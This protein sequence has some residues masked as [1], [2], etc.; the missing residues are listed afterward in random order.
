LARDRVYLDWNA[1]APLRPEARE[2][3]AGAWDLV[4]NPSSVHAEGRASRRLVEDA[5]AVIAGAVGADARN[6]VFTSGGT[7]ANSL[8]LTPGLRQN[9]GLAINRLVVSAIEHAS[10]LTGGRFAREAIEI[11]GVSKSGVVDLGHLREILA[12]G[13]PALVSVMAANNETGALQP[14][15]EVADIV[16]RAGGLLHTDAVQTL[17]KI[18]ID[19][20]V[21]QADLI[22]VS[23]HKIGGPK[24]VGALVLADGLNGLEAAIRGGGQEKGRRAGTEN[25]PGIVG[26]GAAVK[27]AMA[28]LSGDMGRV[29]N[30][31][32]RLETAL[33][34]T[35]GAFVFS[36]AAPRLPNTT[37]F[38][39]PGLKAETAVIGFDLEGIAVS[40]GSACSSGK[41]QPSHVLEAMGFGPEPAK[42]AVRLSLGWSTTEADIDCCLEAWRKLASALLKGYDET[43][44]ERF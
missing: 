31:R 16:H 7:E 11:L 15:A 32:K 34:Q 3:M 8:A 14:V 26:F 18:P 41:V 2:A 12:D 20:K 38:T 30:L 23:A 27:A 22:S 43:E 5:R 37:L 24:G 1:T 13:P 35:R 10:V 36:E 39:V 25:V 6:V 29:E 28:S 19:I 17:G 4:G 21:V 33:R 40:S 42:G 9:S 44:L